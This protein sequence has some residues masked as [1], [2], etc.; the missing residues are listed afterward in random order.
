ML[1][2]A[3]DALEAAQADLAARDAVIARVRGEILHAALN[4]HRLDADCQGVASGEDVLAVRA[5][6]LEAILAQSPADA[7]AAAK[8]E[9]WDEGW[10]TGFSSASHLER[11]SVSAAEPFDKS[12]NPHRTTPT[13]G[14]GQ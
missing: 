6:Y 2:R 9:A 10:D 5:E 13:E 11:E 7:L 4:D 12:I 1:T 8:A 14:G 3:A